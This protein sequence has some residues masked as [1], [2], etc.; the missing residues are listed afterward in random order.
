[1]D[2]RKL[3]AVLLCVGEKEEELVYAELTDEQAAMVSKDIK[4]EIMCGNE[5]KTIDGESLI[6]GS[7][8]KSKKSPR[9]S[10]KAY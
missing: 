5:I 2:K 1:M 7:Q 3:Y 8:I 10:V 6:Q 4:G 9:K